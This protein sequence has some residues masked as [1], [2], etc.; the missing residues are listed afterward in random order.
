[1]MVDGNKSN[2]HMKTSQ[3]QPPNEGAAHQPAAD[4]QS[5]VKK[6]EEKLGDRGSAD[7]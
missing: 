3:H 4:V 6:E 7:H 1:M 5:S 2:N